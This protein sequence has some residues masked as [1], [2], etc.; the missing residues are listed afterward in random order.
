MFKRFFIS[1]LNPS[2]DCS[3]DGH[4]QS[5]R[6]ELFTRS[7][8]SVPPH[9]G[10]LGGVFSNPVQRYNKKTKPPNFVAP[11]EHKTA[12]YCIA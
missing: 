5:D 1:V 11:F 9:E 12:F 4:R 6:A 2:P 10:R 8:E 7:R 3:T